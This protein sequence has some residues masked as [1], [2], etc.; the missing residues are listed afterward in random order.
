[1]NWVVSNAAYNR[2]LWLV[3]DHMWSTGRQVI[4]RVK[5]QSARSTWRM[6]V[7]LNRGLRHEKLANNRECVYIYIY[8]AQSFRKINAVFHFKNSRTFWLILCVCACSVES[9]V[10]HR[11]SVCCFRWPVR[12][13]VSIAFRIRTVVFWV[14]TFGGVV[15]YMVTSVLWRVALSILRLVVVFCS[16]SQSYQASLTLVHVLRPKSTPIILLTL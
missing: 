2:F 13:E 7:G 11:W 8:I 15:W 9:P 5:P 1:M 10:E 14:G 16:F 3:P 6:T 4:S 12:Y